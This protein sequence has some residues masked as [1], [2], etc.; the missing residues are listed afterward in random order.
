VSIIMDRTNT[1]VREQ[2]IG[3]GSAAPGPSHSTVPADPAHPP[4]DNA[5]RGMLVVEKIHCAGTT[6]MG[7][8]EVY[9]MLGGVNGDGQKTSY[10]GPDATQSGDAD[11]QTA[12]DMN[13]SGDL[14]HRTLN[15]RIYDE[16][17][18]PGKSATLALAFVES[19]GQ[20]W[21]ST[22]AAAGKLASSVGDLIKQPVLKIAGLIVSQ[23]ATEIP[24]NQDDML[25]A[26]SLRLG[27]HAGTVVVEDLAPGAYSQI[28]RGVDPS[29]GRFS[30]RFRHDD[31]DYTIDFRVTGR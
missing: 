15:A 12:W 3:H 14:Q 16:P 31:G 25:G 10:R 22:V 26:I 28:T 23:V 4:V 13:D 20:D 27:N 29:T 6:E 18:P 11:N 19:D 30:V 24:K 17:L 2:A 7:H 8:D 21:G 1:Q 5:T 9:Y